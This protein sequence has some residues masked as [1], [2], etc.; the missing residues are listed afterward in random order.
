MKNKKSILIIFIVVTIFCGWLGVIIDSILIDQPDGNTLGMG[1][2]LI[3]PF[4]T[5]IILRFTCRDKKEMGVKPNLKKSWKLYLLSLFIYPVVTAITVGAGLLLNFANISSFELHDFLS[6]VTFSVLANLAK[7]I[8]EEFSWRGFLTPRLIE[9]N[10]S[11]W[12]VYLI[13]GLVWSIW[14]AAYYFVF[15]PENY[16]QATSRVGM[17]IS[18]MVLMLCC[19]IMYVEIYRLTKSVWPCVLLHT[20]NNAIPN[21]LIY[22]TFTNSSNIWLNPVSGIIANL[23]FVAIGLSLRKIRKLREGDLE[24]KVHTS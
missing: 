12:L 16:F 22:I 6:L 1:L 7:N 13:S 5:A 23:L 9:M 10:I 19:T 21:V 14:H 17:F 15:L 20:I 4:L 18:G 11:D 8:F 3:L 2:W 24:E